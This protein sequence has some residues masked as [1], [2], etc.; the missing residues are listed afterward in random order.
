MPYCPKC[1]GE[2]QNWVQVCPDCGV[3]LVDMLPELP[4]VKPKPKAKLSKEPLVYIATAPN[5]PLARMW[6][7]I[8]ENEG[9]YSLVRGSDLGAAMYVPSLLSHSEIHV[10]ASQAEKAREILIPLL[11]D[12]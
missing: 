10:L 6:A 1:R 3:A 11:E 12:S 5:E 4:P 8:L 2:F 7:G 9:I